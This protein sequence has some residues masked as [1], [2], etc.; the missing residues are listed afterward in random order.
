MSLL[1]KI[2]RFKELGALLSY[3]RTSVVVVSRMLLYPNGSSL[4][5]PPLSN[6]HTLLGAAKTRV[7]VFH[8]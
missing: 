1:V 5:M 7:R 4:L 6:S 3:S 2:D 8:A